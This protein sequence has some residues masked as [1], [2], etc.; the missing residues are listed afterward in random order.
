MSW[1]SG[2]K[3]FG[4][5]IKAAIKHIPNAEKRKKFYADVYPA[6]LE[7][8]WANEYECF[9]DD[10]VFEEW[11]CEFTGTL[12]LR[13][14]HEVAIR[15]FESK[16]KKQGFE[17]IPEIMALDFTCEDKD[18]EKNLKESLIEEIWEFV[19]DIEEYGLTAFKH[20]NKC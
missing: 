6:F 7:N 5:V 1:G 4:A 13:K 20:K 18:V 2:T 16:I 12:P 15:V 19:E 11:Y 10:E 8:D 9:Q 3:I 17:N 14:M